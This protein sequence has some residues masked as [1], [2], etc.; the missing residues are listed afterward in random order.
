MK[1]KSPCSLAS[2]RECDIILCMSSTSLQSQPREGIPV[3]YPMLGQLSVC[4]GCCCGQTSKGHPEVPVEWLK[5]EWK[6]RGLLKRVHLTISGCLGPCDVP[7][8]VLI[9][10]A[11]GTQW[12]GQISQKRQYVMLADWAEQSKLADR[13][14]PLP[15]EFDLHRL[16]AFR[17][18]ALG[19]GSAARGAR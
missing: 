17:E 19:V 1:I 15:R 9:T 13:L 2:K 8:V 3:K 4:T 5:Q 14:L 11:E 18:D 6:Y 7:N 10:S 16:A 12:L